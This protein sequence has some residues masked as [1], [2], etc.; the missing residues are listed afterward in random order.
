MGFMEDKDMLRR[1]SVSLIVLFTAGY[2]YGYQCKTDRECEYVNSNRS[3]IEQVEKE[4]RDLSNRRATGKQI[5]EMEKKLVKPSDVSGFEKMK[6]RVDLDS[7]FK[8]FKVDSSGNID[9]SALKTSKGEKERILFFLFSLSVPEQTVENVFS[10]AKDITEKEKVYFYGV[11]RGLNRKGSRPVEA[12][13]WAY[14]SRVNEKAGGDI[15]VKVNP[16]MFKALKV[17]F[18]PAY[19]LADCPVTAGI[20]RS[21]GCEYRG[22]LYGDVSPY[23]AVEKFKERGLW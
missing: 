3:A 9:F 18:V 22:I 16:E 12:R 14:L 2:V 13:I 10:A 6:D 23:F 19:V 4:Y 1:F 21:K 8:M 17:N 11:L 5:E 7:L 15:R 20:I